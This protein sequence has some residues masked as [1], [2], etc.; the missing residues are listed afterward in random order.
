MRCDKFGSMAPKRKALRLS[1]EST[2]MRRPPWWLLAY[3]RTC[4]VRVPVPFKSLVNKAYSSAS[5]NELINMAKDSS[6]KDK[7]KCP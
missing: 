3:S 2:A 7:K 5:S 4:V 1:I 6:K